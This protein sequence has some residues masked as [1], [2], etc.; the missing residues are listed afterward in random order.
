MSPAIVN[1]AYLIAAVF[2]ILGLKGLTHPRTAVR[3][4]LLGTTG[5]VIAVVVTLM[6]GELSFPL[7][8]AGIV[9]GG[10]IGVVLATRIEM[11]AMPQ[12]VAVFNGFGGIASVLVAGAEL[13]NIVGMP[14]L[15]T[16]IAIALS[17]LIGAV[18]F[19]GSLVAFAKLQG[20]VVPDQPVR[21]PGEQIVKVLL[22]IVSVVLGVLVILNPAEISN[23][24]VS[25]N[26]RFGAG[27]FAGDCDWWRRYAGSGRTVEQLFRTCRSG[28][29]FCPVQ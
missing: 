10:A 13:G 19:W 22:L 21:Y 29:R 6:Q 28:H 23:Y 27:N 9:L 18:T 4:N 11:T 17:G 25:G 14:A 24:W 2:F 26:R 5:M 1:L 15:Q 7:I 3:G 8:V 20:V 12:L 16:L